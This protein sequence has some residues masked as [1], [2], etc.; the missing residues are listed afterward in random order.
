MLSA[1]CFD[2][3]YTSAFAR[4]SCVLDQRSGCDSGVKYSSA[5]R[6]LCIATPTRSWS[7][8]SVIGIVM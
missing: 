8:A 4:L 5:S 6:M 3:M 2:G 7:D 1:W